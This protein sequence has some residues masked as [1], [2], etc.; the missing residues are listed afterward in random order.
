MYDADIATT[1]LN[2]WEE[3]GAGLQEPAAALE[4]LREGG[5]RF[6]RIRHNSQ[7]DPG[8]DDVRWEIECLAFDDG[9]AALRLLRLNSNPNPTP[10][11]AVAPG[12]VRSK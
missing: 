4:V 6:K 2:R 5:M 9:S 7:E 3:S 10:W 12:L 8:S 11:A 1:L